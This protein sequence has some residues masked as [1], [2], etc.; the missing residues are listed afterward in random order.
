MSQTT[1]ATPLVAQA[2][3]A[4]LEEPLPFR[5]TAYDGTDIGPRDSDI[6]VRVESCLLYTSPSP[7][8]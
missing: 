5:I 2:V 4:V 3:Q 7:R 1:T 6:A 8:D